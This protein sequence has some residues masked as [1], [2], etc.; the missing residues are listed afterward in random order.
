MKIRPENCIR[1]CIA[2]LMVAV[3][4]G[5]GA[6]T[7]TKR[8]PV[9]EQAALTYATGMKM[10]KL[11]DWKKT[12]RTL[13]QFIEKFPSN[14]NVPLGYLQLAHCR[15]LLE[16]EKGGLEALDEVIKQFPSSK[17][18]RYAWGHK[19]SLAREKKDYDGYIELYEEMVKKFGRAPLSMSLLYSPTYQNSSSRRRDSHIDW[20]RYTSYY[21]RFDQTIEHWPYVRVSGYYLLA[22]PLMGWAENLLQVGDTPVRAR[23]LLAIIDST[24][25]WYGQDLPVDWKFAHVVLLRR[26][27]KGSDAEIAAAEKQFD[28][29]I[30]GFP[31]GDP[32]AMGLWLLEAEHAQGKD[33]EKADKIFN[34]LIETYPGYTS[35]GDRIPARLRYLYKKRR[36]ESYVKLVRWFLK[37]Y[38]T[39]DWRDQGINYWIRLAKQEAAK[40]DTSQIPVILKVL[41]AEDKTY[42]LDPQRLKTNLLHRIDLFMLIKMTRKPVELAEK[43]IGD[44][45]WSAESFRKVEALTRK[46]DAFAKVLEAAR[47][48][49]HI[50]VP[51]PKSKPAVS[52]KELQR[53]IK[54]DQVRHMEEIVDEM[55]EEHRKDAYTIEAVKTLVDYYFGKALHENRNKWVRRM[56]SA[57]PYHP[58]TQQ[59][60]VRQINALRGQKDYKQLGPLLDSAMANFPGAGLHLRWFN[61]RIKC[62]SAAKDIEGRIRYARG[63]LGKRAE[64]G[65]LTAIRKLGD[66]EEKNLDTWKERGDYWI[67]LAV[68]HAGTYQGVYCLTRAF[69]C[70]YIRPTELWWWG[71]VDF[72]SAVKVAAALRKQTVDPEMRWKMM[73]EDIN[74]MAKGN[75][76][77]E[78]LSTLAGRLKE[79]KTPFQLSKLLDLPNFGRAVGSGNL[80]GRSKKVL[81]QLKSMCKLK[82]DLYKFDVLLGAMFQHAKKY[83]PAARYYIQAGKYLLRPIDRWSLHIQATNCLA[84][85][86]TPSYTAVQRK[87][88]G[89]IRTSQDVV[90]RLLLAGGQY[91]WG[92]VLTKKLAMLFFNTL[93]SH[94]PASSYRG[95]AEG[96]MAK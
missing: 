87:Y 25:K 41:D 1:T 43:L 75:F 83:S 86:K 82:S 92:K 88:I 69:Q 38:P 16:D 57:Y 32:R 34:L 20:R 96:I 10:Y 58:L 55:F 51:D 74:M 45:Y 62:F 47:K 3:S 80:V 59:V 81:S 60:M 35:L 12:A 11:G 48:K 13:E 65:E 95:T 94:Y 31:K 68:K 33:D 6:D 39:S 36:H 90:P 73:F 76:G 37:F 21:W 53:R 4:V 26:A 54:D 71:K 5:R 7:K 56:I 50:P 52:F 18:C 28:K 46:D 15:I 44:S 78:A 89:Q 24:L 2:A 64:A 40:K 84:S 23:K 19:L 27:A 79:L 49:W 14:E 29:Y 77:P 17:A 70:Y 42:R 93:R 8:M 85:L 22:A 9:W 63:Y 67:P 61:Y 91:N 66:I 30:K 72:P